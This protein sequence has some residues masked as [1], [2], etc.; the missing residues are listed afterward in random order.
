MSQV[1]SA[2]GEQRDQTSPPARMTRMLWCHGGEVPG[3]RPILSTDGTLCN[4]G[5]AADL[6]VDEAGSQSEALLDTGASQIFIK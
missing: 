4:V 3:G 2:N 6:R 5:T 1:T